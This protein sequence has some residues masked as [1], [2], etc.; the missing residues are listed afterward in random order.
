V[1]DGRLPTPPIFRTAGFR[2][3]EVGAGRTAFEGVPRFD[4]L[5]L[6][7]IVHGGWFGVLLDSCMGC[8]VHTRLPAGKSYTTLEYK[9]NIIRPVGPETGALRAVGEASHVG[10]R[11]GVAEGRIVDAAGR[12]HAQGS[13]TC[14][15]L[16]I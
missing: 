9:V 8:A 12:L 15:I 14:L 10:R 6:L 7:G 16:D 3:A 5:N 4:H 11:T 2:L 13:T 1:L